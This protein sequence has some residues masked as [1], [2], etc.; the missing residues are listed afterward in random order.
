MCGIAGFFDINIEPVQKEM[1]G[2]EML[3]RIKHRGPDASKYFVDDYVFLGHNRLS[4][5][6][7]SADADQPFTFRDY[8]MVYNGEV[9]NYIEL[10]AD[11]IREGYQ[12]DTTSDTE[13]IIKAYHK[14]GE[15]CVDR[16]VG[17]WSLVIYNQENQEIFCSRD[18]FGIK[19]LYYLMAEN[20]FYFASEIKAFYDLDNFDPKLNLAQVY[21]GLNLGWI[22][23]KNETYFD[24]VK[25]LEPA[26]NLVFAQGKIKINTYWRL[27]KTD[28]NLS[29]T[30]AVTEF[31]KKFV[32]SVSIHMR[33]DVKVGACLSGGIDS[34]SIVSTISSLDSLPLESFTIYYEGADA[35]DERPW[36][37]EVLQK[38]K[39]IIPHYFTPSDKEIT[40]HFSEILYHQDAPLPGSSP[41]S[42]YFLMQL[43]GK[44]KIK[45]VMDGQGSDE[46]LFG[47]MHFYYSVYAH[48]LKK[49]KLS[50]A[51]TIFISQKTTQG[52]D[53]RKSMEVIVKS[54]AKF[55]LGDQKYKRKEFEGKYTYVLMH[56]VKNDLWQSFDN[57]NPV[58]SVVQN[59]LF[60]DTLPTLL[61][62]EDRNSMAFSIE[63]R[64][65]FLDHRLVEFAYSLPYSYK[66]YHGKTKRILRDAMADLLPQKISERTDKKGFVTPGEIKWLRGPLKYLLKSENLTHLNDICDMEK[67]GNIIKKF[68]A[69]ENEDATL[70]WR[71]VNL[72][73]WRKTIPKK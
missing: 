59:A 47:Y 2:T 40:T 65:P 5:I 16:F 8:I 12:F 32:E 11:L 51:L 20:V 24:Q 69:G 43:A 7:L 29:Y 13:V 48:L 41:V 55:I 52:Y 34:S 67:V 62:F 54:L 10:K 37:A 18:R 73:E 63:S 70:V 72:N 56:K 50:E 14:W 57:G 60:L 61:H 64:V 27:E 17:M 28:L 35:V 25:S 1:I 4:I 36:V 39:N 19:P 31:K 46:Y 30:E 53:F 68:E 44:N 66:L 21:R 6:D 71:L 49:G 33:S 23:Y 15:N 26:Q 45:V 22:S 58:D 3:Q 38:Y 42:Q 9:Y